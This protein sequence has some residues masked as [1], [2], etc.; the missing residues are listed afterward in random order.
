MHDTLKTIMKKDIILTS[1]LNNFVHNADLQEISIGCSGD[2][3]IKITKNDGIYFLKYSN[4]KNIQSEHE[5]LKW[6]QNKLPVPQ[7]VSYEEQD[8]MYY[9]LT[10]ALDGEMV[11]TPYYMQNQNLGLAVIQKA[12]KLLWN[13]DI[14]DCPFDAG[15]DYKLNYIKT[16][17][18]NNEIHAE[19]IR[20]EFLEKHGGIDSMYK[21]LINN[22]PNETLA[23][24]HGDTSL[25]NIFGQGNELTGFI[26]VSDC[27]I[28]DIWFDITVTAKSV[29]RNYGDN[30][31]QLFMDSIKEKFGT[32]D[33]DKIE[34]YTTLVEF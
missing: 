26:D 7:I 19:D 3:V 22:R 4:R 21:Y 14:H 13:I 33:H 29:K 16:K 18:D 20:T 9:L 28:A 2:K 10:R 8:D 12:F 17:I 11:C 32:I 6:L 34:Y 30:A 15:L 5:K 23:F 1:C 25:P 31:L 24:S 27:G